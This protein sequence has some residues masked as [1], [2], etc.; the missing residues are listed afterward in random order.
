MAHRDCGAIEFDESKC[1][2]CLAGKLLGYR[3]AAV[4]EGGNDG[5]EE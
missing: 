2:C 3:M 5:S 4:V 1:R